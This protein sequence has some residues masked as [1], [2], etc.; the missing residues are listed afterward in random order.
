MC[1]LYYAPVCGNTPEN[2]PATF[3]N[4]C[5]FK[6]MVRQAAGGDFGES[7]GHWEKGV[8]KVVCDYDGNTYEIGESFPA[9]DGCNTCSCMENGNVACTKMA[10]VNP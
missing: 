1:P 5:A 2:E 3:G 8:C 7:K 10:C 6:V 9:T 4:I